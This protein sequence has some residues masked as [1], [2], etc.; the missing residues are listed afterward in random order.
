MKWFVCL[1]GDTADFEELSKSLNNDFL[2]IK[3]HTENKE[4][5]K[6][7]LE[8]ELFDS[9]TD[10]DSVYKKANEIIEWLNGA[11]KLILNLRTLISIS[12]IE[13]I[14]AD[15][16]KEIYV[17]IPESVINL[18]CSI[19]SIL[20]TDKN[21]KTTEI[22]IA[23]PIYEWVHIASNDSNVAKVLR[24]IGSKKLDWVGLYRIFEI[25]QHDVRNIV[26]CGWATKK[27]IDRFKH[28]AN[29]PAAIGDDARHG[30]E[31]T[32]PPNNPIH[33][34]EAKSII[35]NVIHNWLDFKKNKNFL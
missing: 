16:T 5:N 26:K 30:K 7:G 20:T 11:S 4:I 18:R 34:S 3:N 22:N 1:S 33:F 6:F 29:S 14:K 8:S 10:C 28:T 32:S 15:G 12:S 13:K 27:S 24:L 35:E 17:S 9:I 25:I 21:G 19:S 23:D 31:L 2:R